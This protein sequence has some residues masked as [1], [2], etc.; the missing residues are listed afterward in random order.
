MPSSMSESRCPHSCRV[1]R[2]ALCCCVLIQRPLSCAGAPR[3][4]F[5]IAQVLAFAVAPGKTSD[6][7][8]LHVSP[9]CQNRTVDNRSSVLAYAY[10]IG[11]RCDRAVQMVTKRCRE[12]TAL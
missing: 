4:L 9:Y 10:H 8:T 7:Y 2:D 6:T 11:S 3:L 1:H 12:T 5:L